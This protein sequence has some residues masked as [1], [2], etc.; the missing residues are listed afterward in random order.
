MIKNVKA[1]LAARREYQRLQQVRT[2]YGWVMAA[3]FYDKCA[4]AEVEGDLNR[5]H[6]NPPFV[7]GALKALAD[8]KGNM[9]KPL[10]ETEVPAA[11]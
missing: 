3:V 11:D 8:I 1:W 9:S 5:Y 4:V 7:A 6:T 2:G 10:P